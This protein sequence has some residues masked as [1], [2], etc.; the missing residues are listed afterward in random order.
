MED[1]TA[2]IPLQLLS[3]L[4]NAAVIYLFIKMLQ[5]E[6][7]GGKRPIIGDNVTIFANSVVIGGITIGD[8]SQI[9]AGSVVIRDVPDNCIVAGNPA[10]I[11][12]KNG[13]KTNIK[14]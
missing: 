3:M 2:A 5:L 14:L 10:R 7:G 1:C 9:G 6:W 13:I 11:I 4:I 12:R 8:N